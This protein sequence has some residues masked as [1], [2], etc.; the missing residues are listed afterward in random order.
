MFAQMVSELVQDLGDWG[1]TRCYS[2][3][4]VDHS[5]SKL[6][7]H[8]ILCSVSDDQHFGGK[9]DRDEGTEGDWELEKSFRDVTRSWTVWPI[10]EYY[11][12]HRDFS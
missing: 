2:F 8:V 3:G 1:I 5:F 12:H 4:G 10:V 11:F 9:P 7:F 6:M